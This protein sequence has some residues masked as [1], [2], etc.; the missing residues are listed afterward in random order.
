LRVPSAVRAACGGA[1]PVAEDRPGAHHDGGHQSQHRRLEVSQ[2]HLAALHAQDVPVHLWF[3]SSGQFNLLPLLRL[4]LLQLPALKVLLHICHCMQFASY[5]FAIFA[6]KSCQMDS[7]AWKAAW[8]ACLGLANDLPAPRPFLLF[9]GW[10]RLGQRHPTALSQL[11]S[12][13][14]LLCTTDGTCIW[15]MVKNTCWNMVHI[16]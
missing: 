15:N 7:P 13:P 10:S 2:R 3:R 11:L 1:D 9:P 12:P 16:C 6:D 14:L 4:P 8:E 5:R